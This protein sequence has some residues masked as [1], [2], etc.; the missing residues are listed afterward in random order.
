MVRFVDPRGEVATPVEPYKASVDWSQ[1]APAIGLLANGFP[2]SVAFLGEVGAAIEQR[3]PGVTVRSW[4][5]GDPS[6][7]AS[8]QLLDGIAEEV[9]AVIAAYGH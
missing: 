4:D 7:P 1:G 2:G 9:A 8:D 6:A 3:V 5:K